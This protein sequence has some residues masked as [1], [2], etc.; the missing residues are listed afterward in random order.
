MGESLE[1]E[2]FW[3]QKVRTQNVFKQL[4]TLLRECCTRLYAANKIDNLNVT[5]ALHGENVIQTDVNLKYAKSTVGYYR[6]TAN[7]DVQ[8]KLQQIQDASNQCVRALQTLLKGIR[9]YDEAVAS[10]SSSERIQELI[11][12]VLSLV[13]KNIKEAR[14]SL[15]LPKRKSLVELC[16][17]QPIKSFNPPLPHDILLSYY[18]A[19]AKLVCAAYQVISKVN[20]IQ[21]V[22]IYTAECDLPHLVEVLKLLSTSFSVAHEFMINYCMLKR[23]FSSLLIVL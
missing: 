23:N 16:Q 3:L 19:S 14:C 7:P 5:V 11:L 10:N 15:T 8:W 13:K 4:E 21:T 22:T 17:F 9:K 12:T 18:I 1:K 2:G 20:G 6:A